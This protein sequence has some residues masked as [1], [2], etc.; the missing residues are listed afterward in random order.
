MPTSY[1][2]NSAVEAAPMQG[3][4]ILYDPDANRFC[5]LN[6]TA[7]FLWERLEEP[8]TAGELSQALCA[9]FDGVAVEQAERDVQSA[10]ARFQDLALVV[11]AE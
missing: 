1:R 4:T 5:V 11:A 8:H 7:A 6:G 10:L 9:G 3:E 2:R